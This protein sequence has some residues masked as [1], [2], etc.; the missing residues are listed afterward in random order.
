MN[1]MNVNRQKQVRSDENEI[2]PF[3]LSPSQHYRSRKNYL[4][5]LKSSI[6]V[7]CEFDRPFRN[8]TS[9]RVIVSQSVSFVMSTHGA[10][11]AMPYASLR[12]APQSSGHHLGHHMVPCTPATAA[13]SASLEK[14]VATR[15]RADGK[16]TALRGG[17]GARRNET[18]LAL[19]YV[20]RKA[21]LSTSLDA[22][23]GPSPSN[24]KQ[25]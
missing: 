8:V 1:D 2:L 17:T 5:K 24:Y 18:R 7:C 12:G 19:R 11:T 10:P 3:R 20:V 16:R 15:N 22:G 14:R 25:S 23:A 13:V 21:R 4:E 9:R 6:I